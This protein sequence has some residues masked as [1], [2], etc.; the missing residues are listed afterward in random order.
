MGRVSARPLFKDDAMKRA[1]ILILMLF[2]C[3]N[4]FAGAIAQWKMNDDANDSV[5]VDSVGNHTGTY[6]D[7]NGA[8]AV[9]SDHNSV[10]HIN[11]SLDFDGDNDYIT[12]ADHNDFTPAG[13]PFSISMW[14]NMRSFVYFIPAGKWQN[15][16][17]E[18]W[19]LY[20]G[21]QKR[22]FFHMYDNS[23]S[24][25]IGRT[26]GTSLGSY[27]NKWTHFVATYDGG[28][29]SS[30]IKIYLNGNK[31][32]DDDSESGSFS[33]VKNLTA[34][35]WIG[36][37][38][39]NYSNGLIDNVAI[40]DTALTAKEVVYLYNRGRGTENISSTSPRQRT[41]DRSR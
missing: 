22:I 38:S 7:E 35:V 18:E 40:F 28:T 33:S 2:L 15:G 32:D 4:C 31:V 27:E 37:Y 16:S 30:G 12:I 34:P 25:Y 3:S 17:N 24:V 20:T 9:T 14:A 1:L 26:Y 23:N 19:L 10:G 29:R 41:R 8:A 6:V 39:A 13:T 5:V 11:G 36:R 21:T